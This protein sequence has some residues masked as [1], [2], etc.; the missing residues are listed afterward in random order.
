V[1][2]TPPQSLITVREHLLGAGDD[3]EVLG[4]VVAVQWHGDTGRY[5]ARH[6][7]ECCV[8]IIWAGEEFDC[9]PEHVPHLMMCAVGDTAKHVAVVWFRLHVVRR[10]LRIPLG[11]S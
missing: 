8:G 1:S 3:E 11:G 5:H 7:A 4:V 2:V 6:D 9:R 10:S